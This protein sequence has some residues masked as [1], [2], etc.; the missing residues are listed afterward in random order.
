MTLMAEASRVMNEPTAPSTL[1]KMLDFSGC[2]PLSNGLSTA[3]FVQKYR[4]TIQLERYVPLL[5][6]EWAGEGPVVRSATESANCG[7][8]LSQSSTAQANERVTEHERK[9]AAL[10]HERGNANFK[11]GAF[12]RAAEDYTQSLAKL[13]GRAVD[14]VNL[15]CLGSDTM[16][17]VTPDPST[18]V[19][20]ARASQ[21]A[22]RLAKLL[23]NRAQVRMTPSW[24][25]SWPTSAFYTAVFPPESV[26]QLA[27]FGQT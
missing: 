16:T 24:P 4:P 25:R 17:D 8:K 21:Q 10:C 15:K 22:D 5:C 14:V 18:E 6:G 2:S 3:A 27:S 19:L 20:A 1:V 23:G 12:A 9:G 7:L 13:L 11:R 26:D